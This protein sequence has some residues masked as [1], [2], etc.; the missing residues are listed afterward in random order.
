MGLMDRDYMH[1]RQRQRPFSPPPERSPWGTLGALLVFVAAL[2]FLYKAADWIKQGAAPAAN[3]HATTSAVSKNPPSGPSFTP[4]RPALPPPQHAPDA[5]AG[6]STVSKCVVNGATSYS[7]GPCPGGALSSQITTHAN[8][9]LMAAV[10]PQAVRRTEATE[11]PVTPH[12]AV[13]VQHEAVPAAMAH[14]A[15]CEY[16]D[17]QIRRFDAMARQPQSGQMQDWISEQRKQARDRQFRIR[18][19]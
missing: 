18:C 8:H 10:R 1:D 3:A 5:T 13:V 7:D 2:F 12:P 15:E 11:A 6:T 19:Q 14:Q 9:N 16:L 17:A 4:P